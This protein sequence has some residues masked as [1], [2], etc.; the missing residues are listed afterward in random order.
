M[1]TLDNKICPSQRFAKQ[2]KEEY[3][4]F[5]TTI[6]DA[7]T[8]EK[9]VGIVQP[10]RVLMDPA[11]FD[12]LKNKRIQWVFNQETEIIACKITES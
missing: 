4:V 8:I 7:S 9:W 3:N 5:S 6:E 11:T 2:N 12:Q 10:H 1:P